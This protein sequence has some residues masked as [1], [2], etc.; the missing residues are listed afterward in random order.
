[1]TGV[2]M[3]ATA[4]TSAL[5]AGWLGR[6]GDRIGH[7]PIL[8]ASAI[9]AALLYLPQAFVSAAWQLVV[10]QALSGIA[11]GG[12]LPATAALMNLWAPFG[13][14][15]VTYGLDNSV[16][17]AARSFAPMLGAGFALWFGMRGV[18]AGAALVYMVIAVVAWQVAQAARKED[19]ELVI[20]SSAPGD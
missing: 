3:G 5:S 11:V 19:H 17:A 20:A 2:V 7:R 12:L 9:L 16:Q 8:V 1:M 10:L 18:Y 13:K 15:G 6:L 4:F 14:Q